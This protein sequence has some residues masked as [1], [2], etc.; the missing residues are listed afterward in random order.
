MDFLSILGSF[1]VVAFIIF[2]VLALAVIFL[3][4]FIRPNGSN[5][6]N[7]YDEYIRSEYY[8]ITDIPYNEMIRDRGRYGEYLIYE[9]LNLLQGGTK[10]FL[11]NVYLPFHNGSMTEID[12]IFIHSSGVYVIESKN[13]SGWIFGNESQRNWTECIKAGREV[14]KYRFYN[15]IMQNTV[16]IELL[17]NYLS[18]FTGIPFFS[19]IVFGDKC[20]LK[21]ITY[22]SHKHNVLKRQFLY[23]E[24]VRNINN[25]GNVLS[26]E[27]I[28]KIY[29]RLYPY[30]KVSDEIK[31]SHIDRIKYNKEMNSFNGNYH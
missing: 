19:C 30:S 23:D 1:A 17:Q 10:K 26:D 16:H 4:G 24:M 20:E 11:F 27:T 6:K 18:D 31:K 5:Y 9:S 12:I 2:V 29:D 25:V 13:Y 15:P 7:K 3:D 14:Q 8:K 28:C 22:T 21:K